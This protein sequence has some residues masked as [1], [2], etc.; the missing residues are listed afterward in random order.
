MPARAG[1][2]LRARLRLEDFLPYRLSVVANVVSAALSAAYSR[3]FGLSIPEWRV[4]A[5][6]A[7]HPDLSAAQVAERT[8]EIL[9]TQNQLK[10]TLDAIRDPMFEADLDGL[11][12]AYSAPGGN[13]RPSGGGPFLD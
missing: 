11:V 9:A 10:S 7:N 4:V 8:A 5:V 13:P 1:R 2:R 12:H 6:L 3:R